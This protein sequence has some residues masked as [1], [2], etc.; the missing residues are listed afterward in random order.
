MKKKRKLKLL[1]LKD[2]KESLEN[3]LLL[4]LELISIKRSFMIIS[5]RKN[6]EINI[7]F[8]KRLKIILTK[9]TLKPLMKKKISQPLM[10]MKMKILLKF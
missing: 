1:A 9:K 3:L 10:N 6:K 2:Y 4:P 8:L 7:L 5:L